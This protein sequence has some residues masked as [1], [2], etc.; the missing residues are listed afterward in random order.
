MIL[1]QSISIIVVFSSAIA[2]TGSGSLPAQENASANRSPGPRR[3]RIERFPQKSSCRIVTLPDKTIPTETAGS[4]ARKM[5]LFLPKLFS[6]ASRQ[7]SR[8]LKLFSGYIGEQGA[9][10]KCGKIPDHH[11]FLSMAFISHKNKK[12][13]NCVGNTT[14]CSRPV[15]Y[16][17]TEKSRKQ[18]RRS[19]AAKSGTADR[20]RSGR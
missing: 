16:N 7:F 20:N 17:K 5:N 13:F 12:S 14:E 10:F 6:D 11:A 1:R 15:Y 8:R 18:I 9:A 2:E 19:A 4:P 3:I